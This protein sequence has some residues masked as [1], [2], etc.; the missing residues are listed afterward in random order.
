MLHMIH[1]IWG[2][3]KISQ[4]THTRPEAG[5]QFEFHFYFYSGFISSVYILI[6]T[7]YASFLMR[8][9]LAPRVATL[10]SFPQLALSP[11]RLLDWLFFRLR[12]SPAAFALPSLLPR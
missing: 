2:L 8:F 3:R 9:S 12:F 7:L 5:T 1:T 10:E 6:S 4:S 11:G